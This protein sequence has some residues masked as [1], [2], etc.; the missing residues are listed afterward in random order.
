MVECLHEEAVCGIYWLRQ[1]ANS[2]WIWCGVSAT[3]LQWPM[4]LTDVTGTNPFFL[5]F[6]MKWILPID[7]GLFD[8]VDFLSIEYL[9][10]IGN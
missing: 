9:S 7:W 1:Y 6:W 3:I 10:P 2:V 8:V 5:R 4:I